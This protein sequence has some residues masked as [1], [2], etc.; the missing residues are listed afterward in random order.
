[1]NRQQCT[2]KACGFKGHH[3][4]NC[5]EMTGQKFGALTV[6][7]LASARL[8]GTDKRSGDCSYA[9]VKCECG[10]E[11]EVRVKHLRNGATKSCGCLRAHFMAAAVASTGRKFDLPDAAGRFPIFG[12]MMT[13]GEIAAASGMRPDQIWCKMRAGKTAEEAVFGK[14]RAEAVGRIIAR[15]RP[16]QDP[17]NPPSSGVVAMAEP[18][19]L[20]IRVTSLESEVAALR[21][22]VD[23]LRAKVAS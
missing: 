22:V 18:P 7:R 6:L 3:T 15:S 16:I 13:L 5:R 8:Q 2:C 1:M 19:T 14:A 4:S 21:A 23:E 11:K 12:E 20:A 10:T 9:L 17:D